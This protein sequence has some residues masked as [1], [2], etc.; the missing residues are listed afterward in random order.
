VAPLASRPRLAAI[1]S[2]PPDPI[3]S[4]AREVATAA[5]C[6]GAL[7][8]TVE[9]GAGQAT[10]TFT[11]SD[12]RA[13]LDLYAL[14]LIARRRG[15]VVVSASSAGGELKATLLLARAVGDRPA[16]RP[17]L[18]GSARMLLARALAAPE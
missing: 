18:L 13:P 9:R 7:L 4:L 17:R 8:V 10:A 3:E 1:P 15:A 5:E 14:D 12:A 16:A 11:V 2:P 6:V